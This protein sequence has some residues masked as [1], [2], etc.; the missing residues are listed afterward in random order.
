MSGLRPNLQ[1]GSW[2][3]SGPRAWMLRFNVMSWSSSG[4]IQCFNSVALADSTEQKNR[5][6]FCA[7]AHLSH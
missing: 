3:A 4:L 7:T 6:S 1:P 2:G 5:N